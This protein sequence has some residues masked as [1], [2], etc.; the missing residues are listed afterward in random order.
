MRP[1]DFWKC[2]RG[3]FCKF[4]TDAH[5]TMGVV[6][7]GKILKIFWEIKKGVATEVALPVKEL[8]KERLVGEANLLF[9]RFGLVDPDGAGVV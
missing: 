8:L 9:E 6:L 7:L 4:R 2:W 5:Q 1:G 3:D